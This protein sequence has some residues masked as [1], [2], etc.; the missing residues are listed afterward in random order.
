MSNITV[1]IPTYKSW[2]LLAKCLAA[3]SRQTISEPF[4]I[5]VINNDLDPHIP[6]ELKVYS[7]VT[8]LQELKEGSYAA[9][10]MG[11][12]NTQAEI[13]AFTDAD[14]IPNER[15][16]EE[17]VKKLRETP[18]IGVVAGHITLFYKDI[19]PNSFEIYEKYTALNQKGYVEVYNECVTAN[20]FSYKRIIDEFGG[21]DSNLKSNGDSKLSRLI[22]SRYLIVYEEKAIVL[23]PARNTKSSLLNK[24]RRLIG[25][26]FNNKY[27]HDKKGFN[28][29]VNNFV[30]RRIRFNFN[31]VLKGKFVDALHVFY[32]HCLLFPQ[33]FR[34]K[35]IILQTGKTQ[36]L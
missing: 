22:S 16:L 3:L 6:E 30:L 5:I 17:G 13:I 32:V 36:R 1:L 20:W 23:H 9:R 11:L 18:N 35:R 24:Y 28:R 2:D 27:M 12:A 4:E 34:E 33:L 8:F 14:C 7:N 10:N 25:G 21:F 31:L 29:Y 26:A 19:L 15:W